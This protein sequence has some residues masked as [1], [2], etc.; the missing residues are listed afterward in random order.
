MLSR[1][2]QPNIDHFNFGTDNVFLKGFTVPGNTSPIPGN[3][4][5]LLDGTPM[6]LLDG[7]FFLLLGS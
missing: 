1:N 7:S 6:L 2:D 3:S 4:F 5:L